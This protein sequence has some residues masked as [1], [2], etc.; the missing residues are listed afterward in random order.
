MDRM[1]ELKG[2]IKEGVG[3]LTD[4]EQ[5]EAEGKA[6]AERARVGREVEGAADSATGAVQEG[7]GKLTGDA[8]TEAE[9]KVRQAGG[10]IKRAG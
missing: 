4:N 3:G 2:R 6:E 10:D 5:Q 7:W 1:D 8:S 9:G